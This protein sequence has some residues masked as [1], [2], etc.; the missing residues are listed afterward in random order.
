MIQR[1]REEETQWK[2]EESGA[3]D[4][5]DRTSNITM[6][7][8][9]IEEERERNTM[10]ERERE[11]GGGG[12]SDEGRDRT[13]NLTVYCDEYEPARKILLNIEQV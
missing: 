1:R 6:Y 10:E 13:S 4:G 8:D 9:E 3:E 12:G 2:L 11:R 7:Y 5:R